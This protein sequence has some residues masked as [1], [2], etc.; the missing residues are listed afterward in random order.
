MAAQPEETLVLDL[1]VG[2]TSSS[3]EA[4]TPGRCCWSASQRS[5]RSTP[6]RPRT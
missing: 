5:W 2:M 1:L 6:R 4:W 3:L